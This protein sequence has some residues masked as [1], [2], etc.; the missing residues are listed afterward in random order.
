MIRLA[1]SRP[2]FAFEER[3]GLLVVGELRRLAVAFEAVA[4][5]AEE[6][7]GDGAR[8][9]AADLEI[10]GGFGEGAVEVAHAEP[11]SGGEQ[12]GADEDE[13]DSR[14]REG[15]LSCWWPSARLVDSGH[16]FTL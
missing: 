6:A 5:A 10:D 13:T 14:T 3:F 8:V 7:V 12:R 1:R 16:Q 9:G 15:V 4:L 2:S 11:G